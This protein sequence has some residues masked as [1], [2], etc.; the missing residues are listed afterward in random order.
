MTLLRLLPVAL[1]LG[2]LQV[3]LRFKDEADLARRLKERDPQAMSDLYDRYGRV[4]YSLIFRIVRNGAAAEDLVQETFLRVWN[5]VQS[6][7]QEKGA[8]GPWVLTVARNRAIDYLRSID[9]R[10]AAGAL[11]LDRVENPA[12]FCDFTDNALSIDRARR[13]K[14]AFEK[15]NPNQR[16][17]IELAYYEGLSQTEM[18]EQMKQPLGTVKTWVRTALKILRDELTE[19]AIA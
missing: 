16:M 14:G 9:G 18:A 2:I 7:D 12:L 19:A 11:E 1:A 13:L 5:R 10:M 4:A 3:V 15:L 8:L 6:F 17:V